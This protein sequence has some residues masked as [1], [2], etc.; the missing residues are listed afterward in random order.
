M[1]HQFRINIFNVPLERIAAQVL[2]Q[3]QTISD[4]VKNRNYDILFILLMNT[5]NNETSRVT[6]S[7]KGTDLAM[8][9]AA[10]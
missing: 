1:L 10:K 8:G 5:S 9:T 7:P 6:Y 3:A 4:A 2:S